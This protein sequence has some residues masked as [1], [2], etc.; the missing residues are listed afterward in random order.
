MVLDNSALSVL[1]TI[2]NYIET[3]VKDKVEDIL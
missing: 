3:S 1:K 2:D